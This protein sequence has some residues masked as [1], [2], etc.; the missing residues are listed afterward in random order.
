MNEISEGNNRDNFANIIGSSIHELNKHGI[1]YLFSEEQVDEVKKLF[2]EKYKTEIYILK[3]DFYWE[4]RK[5]G[6]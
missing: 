6:K 2:E 4:L 3:K 5:K 1:V